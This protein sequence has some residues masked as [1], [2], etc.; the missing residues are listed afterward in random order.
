M[1]HTL[2]DMDAK[3]LIMGVHS[4]NLYNTHTGNSYITGARGCMAFIA[5]EPEVACPRRVEV[6]KCHASRVRV[7]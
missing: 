4:N 2:E 5:S 7:I 6:N 3:L 1:S